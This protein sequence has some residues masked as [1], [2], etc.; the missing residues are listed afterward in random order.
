MSSIKPPHTNPINARAILRPGLLRLLGISTAAG[1]LLWSCTL[2]DEKLHES[3]TGGGTATG[4][5]SAGGGD[6]GGQAANW[7]AVE[8]ACPVPESK[9]LSSEVREHNG[10]YRL[11]DL[12]DDIQTCGK[13]S[14]VDGPDGVLGIELG[15]DERVHVEASFV[16]EAGEQ[17]PEVDLGVYMMN[18]CDSNTCAKR[19]ERCPP[20]GGEHFAW[21]AET[22]G[23]YYFGFDSKAY[24][25]TMYD[26]IVQLSVTFPVCGNGQLEKGETCDDGNRT[27]LDGCSEECLAEVT[28]TG[29]PVEVEPNNYYLTGNVVVLA[30]GETMAIKGY[31]GGG[32]DL[33]FYMLDIPEGGFARATMLGEDGQDCPEGTPP[34]V[35]E[36]DDPSGVAELGKAKIPADE[37]GS[38][39]CPQWDENSFVTSSL[40][41]GRYVVEMKPYE[42]GVG[43]DPFPYVL[44]VEILD[45]GG[46]SGGGGG[47]GA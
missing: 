34:F 5:G 26:P 25:E 24:D 19:V 8:D 37:G 40:P 28:D 18:A 7:N 11:N 43:S 4:T 33:D 27:S 14:G 38:N 42:K 47:G 32:C 22:G 36:F 35:L 6:T 39:Y 46:G 3:A 44:N 29:Q 45:A 12:A 23:V 31:I 41:A 20:G 9:E 10:T 16:I 2:F 15:A 17:P 13:L 21:S 30:P 1:A